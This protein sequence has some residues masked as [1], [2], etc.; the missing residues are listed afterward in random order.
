MVVQEPEIALNDHVLIE[1][2]KTSRYA[3]NLP[4]LVDQ[5]FFWFR[6]PKLASNI[7][8]DKL[9]RL[10]NNPLSFLVHRNWQKLLILVHFKNKLPVIFN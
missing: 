4:C 2:V 9:K 1:L 7:L 10:K 8:F 5:N 3:Q 6:V